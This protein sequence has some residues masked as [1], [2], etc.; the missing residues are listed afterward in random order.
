MFSYITGLVNQVR[1]WDASKPASRKRR[2]SV[3]H[4]VGLRIEALE[5]RDVPTV[6]IPSAF[7]SEAIHGSTSDGMQNPPVVLLF[8]GSYWST[9]NGIQD[10]QTFK[11]S[12]AAIMSG[13]YLSDLTEYG[14]DGKAT[15]AECL[16]TPDTVTIGGPGSAY[17][18][19]ADPTKLQGFLKNAINN[20]GVLAPGNHDWQHA[21]IY[22]VISDPTSS[23]GSGT[24][25][26]QDG[27]YQPASGPSENIHMIWL[28]TIQDSN[29]RPDKDNFT[30]VFSHELVE[31]M[32]DPDSNGIT[33]T[34][35][36]NLPKSV[37]N[38][39][40]VQIC[41][42]EPDDNRYQY[43]LNDALNGGPGDLVQAY[44]SAHDQAF[45]VPDGNSQ[46]VELQP[47]W[48]S[49]T[50]NHNFNLF[51]SGDQL[52]GNANDKITLDTIHDA[53]GDH[54]SLNLNQQAF[55]FEA[56]QIVSIGINTMSGSN[57][58]QINSV[59]APVSALNLQSMTGTDA[60]KIGDLAAI[61]SVN[62]IDIE[63]RS[64]QT[65]LFVN[66]YL[67]G[68]ASVTLENSSAVTSNG[69][70]DFGSIFFSHG[71][72]INYVSRMQNGQKSGLTSIEIDV[73]NG[74]S[75]N[76]VE[77][78]SFTTITV[79]VGPNDPVFGPAANQI[80]VHRRYWIYN[81]ILV[82]GDPTTTKV[83]NF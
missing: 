20:D 12:A 74:S 64:G 14:S 56:D 15:F 6:I 42:D 44:W 33:V 8:S 30:D 10:M 40:T 37:L 45:I 9:A 54:L 4:R 51:L 63:N 81:P 61:S 24:G 39:G 19:S 72:T 29:G 46:M 16:T 66:G 27:Q 18:G 58:V 71:P 1:F 59:P 21:P 60:I 31:R 22:V 26:N 41:D 50:F 36:S 53:N 38:N 80:Y 79:D 73:A 5:Q 7:G 34:P 3:R 13:P 17:P 77:V 35:P 57:S 83:A 43:R 47:N 62:S 49:T 75:I 68:P 25:W 48:T 32:S 11:N 70:F 52:P 28:Y 65:S 67:D 78:G 23:Q 69:S 2:P 76:A 82:S 55:V